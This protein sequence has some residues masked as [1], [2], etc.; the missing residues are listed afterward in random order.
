[1]RRQSKVYRGGTTNANVTF[2]VWNVDLAEGEL[3]L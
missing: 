2:F 3:Q 1:M